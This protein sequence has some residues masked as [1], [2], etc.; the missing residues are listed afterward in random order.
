MGWWRRRAQVLRRPLGRDGGNGLSCDG[1]LLG[2]QSE[3]RCRI[4]E[5]HDG[6]I[7]RGKE[8]HHGGRSRHPPGMRQRG[9][10]IK[11]AEAETSTGGRT[12]LVHL[13]EGRVAKYRSLISKLSLE[14]I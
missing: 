14:M 6:D 11:N 7:A 2:H 9:S 3:T 4:G 12:G 5:H 8:D 1:K 13:V 10:T